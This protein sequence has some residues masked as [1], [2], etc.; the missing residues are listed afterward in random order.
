MDSLMHRKANARLRLIRKDGTP[1]SGAKVT[2]DQTSHR[3]LFGCGA[4][5]AVALMKVRDD[6][7][8]AFYQERMD[9]WL[10]LFNYGTLPFYWGRYEPVEGKTAYTETMAAARWLRNA[11]FR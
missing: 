9:K 6:Q 2:I 10:R 7:R 5:D 3:F 4:F 11:A 1:L 8:R